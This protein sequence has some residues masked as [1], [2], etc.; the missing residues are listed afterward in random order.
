MLL[1]I[2]LIIRDLPIYLV[3][4]IGGLV[5]SQDNVEIAFQILIEEL[6]EAVQLCNKNY[7]KKIKP[8]I[9]NKLYE[10]I[11]KHLGL[12]KQMKL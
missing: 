1:K 7:V 9:S 6:N 8:W 5:Y 12:H 10:M 2:E 11:S 4:L 3:R